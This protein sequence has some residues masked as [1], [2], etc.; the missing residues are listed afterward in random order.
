MGNRTL[1]TMIM[2]Q[3]VSEIESDVKIGYIGFSKIN[4]K[5]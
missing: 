1:L 2:K 3:T 4:G 5:Q